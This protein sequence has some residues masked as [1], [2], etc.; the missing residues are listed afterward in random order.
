MRASQK[1]QSD[2]KSKKYN[3]KDKRNMFFGKEPSGEE[4]ETPSDKTG[5]YPN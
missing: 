5:D 3:R 2:S 1:S 4:F